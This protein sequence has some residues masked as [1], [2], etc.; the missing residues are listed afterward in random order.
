MTRREFIT[1][2]VLAYIRNNPE[3]WILFRKQM[4]ERRDRLFDPSFGQ[5]KAVVNGRE[6]IDED[7]F[8]LT[9]SLPAKLMTALRVIIQTDESNAPLFEPKGEM[10][11]FKRKFPEFMLT[12]RI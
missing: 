12:A 1:E 4:Q 6:K 7:S 11:W 5:F 8:R 9:L 10:T 2:C 3:E